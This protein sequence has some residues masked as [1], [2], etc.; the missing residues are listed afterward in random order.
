MISRGSERA[1]DSRHAAIRCSAF[2]TGTTTD[3][4]SM[5]GA[6]S[7]AG[8]VYTGG[9][10]DVLQPRDDDVRGLIGRPR[11]GDL[12]QEQG[13]ALQRTIDDRRL[14]AESSLD[15]EQAGRSQGRDDLLRVARDLV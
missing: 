8:L 4:S 3:T 11:L 12:E 15:G 1:I 13:L 10:E 2:R 5:K 6:P 9:R 7:C 14:V